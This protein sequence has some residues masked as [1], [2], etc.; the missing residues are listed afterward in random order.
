MAYNIHKTI[1]SSKNSY[2]ID[3]ISSHN[4]NRTIYEGIYISS[5]NPILLYLFKKAYDDYKNIFIYDIDDY[6]TFTRLKISE[7]DRIYCDWCSIANGT[8]KLIIDSIIKLK[9][10][11]TNKLK[12]INL[13]N[14]YLLLR[15]I[16]TATIFREKKINSHDIDDFIYKT[17]KK[18]DNKLNKLIRLISE[19]YLVTEQIELRWCPFRSMIDY[20]RN[21]DPRY[22]PINKDT[23]Y[24][25][26]EILSKYDTIEC[27]FCNKIL[28]NKMDK[29]YIGLD[30]ESPMLEYYLFLKE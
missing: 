10:I 6:V 2:I 23:I 4:T 14:S 29:K 18:Y 19:L 3:K 9:D 24:Y 15:W 16:K 7:R 26:G 27:H 8:I 21:Y 5:E 28:N 17:F 22:L 11:E 13:F 1:I 12:D 30:T 25:A 20:Y